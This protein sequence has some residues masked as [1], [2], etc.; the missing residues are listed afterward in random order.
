MQEISAGS[1]IFRKNHQAITY[2]IIHQING[3]HFGFPKGHIEPNESIEETIKRECLEEVG[4]T[5]EIL[6]FPMENHYQVKK[7][8]DKKVIYMLSQT[9][10]TTLTFQK[11]ELY[12]A[13]FLTYDQAIQLLTYQRDQ[14]ILTYY[15]QLIKELI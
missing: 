1:V 5:I 15:H 10:A 4:I 2:V 14:D 7:N 13:L 3:N 12:D 9:Q 6:G 11:E 8:M